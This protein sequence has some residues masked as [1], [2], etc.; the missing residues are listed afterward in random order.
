M[1]GRRPVRNTLPHH[2]GLDAKINVGTS[3]FREVII[4]NA[5]GF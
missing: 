1:L 5:K 2:R 4:K 3:H